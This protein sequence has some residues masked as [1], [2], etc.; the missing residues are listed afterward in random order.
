MKKNNISLTSEIF[1]KGLVSNSLVSFI[2]LFY[3][4]FIA[5]IKISIHYPI[6]ILF[7][8][9]I[10][11][12]EFTVAP[13]TNFL[14]TAHTSKSLKKW[15]KDGS[16]INKRTKLFKALHLLPKLKQI[17]CFI[18]F[19]ICSVFLFIYFLFFMK[20][21]FVIC[22]ATLMA[23]LL[24]SYVAGLFSITY[25]RKICS[26]YEKELVKEGIDESILDKKTNFGLPYAKNFFTFCIIP[27]IWCMIIFFIVFY[28]YY[29]NNA[30]T[31]NGIGYTNQGIMQLGISKGQLKRLTLI[32]VINIIMSCLSVYSFLS[33]I[34]VSSNQ[35]QNSMTH[36]IKNDIFTVD[37]NPT[38]FDNEV[39]YNLYLV[40]KVVLL[41]RTIFDEISGIGQT[42]IAPINNIS[43]ISSTTATTSL[44]QSTGVKE[45][46][47]TMEETD[48]QTR[49][50]VDKIADV[51]EIAENTAKNVQSGFETLQSNL[52]KMNDITEANV[53]T[54]A[55]IRELGEKIGSI[56]E[57]VKIIND[58]ADQTRI[59]AFNAELEASSAG[60][61][62]KNFHIVA[63]EVRRLA[64]GIT[65]SVE[66]IKE[67]ITEIQHSSD[68]LIITSESG[69]EKI[70]EGLALSEKLKEKFSDIQSS[71]EITVESA[72]QIKEIIYQQS[73]A[74]DQIVTTVR[75]ISAGIENFSSSTG[76]MN[77]TAKKLQSA[78]NNLEN[79]HKMIVQ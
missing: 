52:D 72:L 13:F 14:I 9:F 11:F 18:Y 74:F 44:E 24:G 50:I 3:S 20:V 78:A 65:N 57:I 47:A 17:E 27:I 32:L 62:G 8:C 30:E 31:V 63:N 51:T 15:K 33:A 40:N 42:M 46:L 59:I 76:T 7:L 49:E 45:I 66:Q 70:R 25:S 69:T 5:N 67:R 34:L 37:L 1:F 35:L 75:Q 77:E 71:S 23:C 64:S 41:F 43:E 26:V 29:H 39:A 36:I 48:T 21:N 12:V 19:V 6:I 2:V 68:N 53:T 38:D 73:A 4:I 79:L 56:W 28:A 55:G 10:L 54:I 60:D 61:L 58:I 16:D 22:A